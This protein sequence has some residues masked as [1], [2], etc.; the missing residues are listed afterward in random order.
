V[1]VTNL[2]ERL[3][4]IDTA[5]TIGNGVTITA[6]GDLT[7]TGD[8]LVSGDT[9]TMNTATMAVEDPLIS[10]ASGNAADSLDV[11][12]YAK[13]VSSGTKYAG[14]FRDASDSD[15]WKLFATTGNSHA[16]PT[17][18]VNTTSGFTLGTLVA[19]TFEGALTG[20]VTG[21][22][23]GNAD[24]VTDGVTVGTHA[25]NNNLAYF[26]SA[27]VISNTNNISITAVTGAADFYGSVE[28]G[29]VKIGTDTNKNT[30]ETSSAQ[31]LVLRTNGGTNS[32]TLTITDGAN[33]AITIAPN[34]SGA[35][36]ITKLTATNATLVTPALGTPSALVLTN[37]TAL[38]AAQVAQ[39]TMASGM[40]LVAPALGTPASGVLT[41]ATGLP[42]TSLT[43]T[44]TNAQLAG[45]IVYSKLSLTGAVL[46]AD[47]ASGIS[48]TKLT[49]GTIP[50]A[51]LGT[52]NVDTTHLADD[53]V[54]SDKIGAGEV[55]NTAL[56]ASGLSASKLTIGTLPDARY[57]S[58]ISALTEVGAKTAR[59]LTLTA[60]VSDN[61]QVWFKTSQADEEKYFHSGSG[62]NLVGEIISIGTEEVRV[63]S[64]ISVEVSEPISGYDYG[65]KVDRG[66]RGTT[67]AS[68]YSN[69][70]TL[71]ATSNR[72]IQTTATGSGSAISISM[73]E[74]S[75]ASSNVASVTGLVPKATT[76]DTAKYLRGDG[77]WQTVSAGGDSND[78]A[79][80]GSASAPSF[81]FTS[82]TNT[83]IFRSAADT[84]GFTTGGTKSLTIAGATT[85]FGTGSARAVLT[86]SGS[87]QLRLET[88]GTFPPQIT[89]DG[90]NS[91]GDISL[92][93]NG[94][95]S[96]TIGN[97][98]TSNNAGTTI[99]GATTTFGT[100][101]GT[102]QLKSNGNQ[103]LY[104][105]TGHSSTGSIN[106][107]AGADERIIL[108]PHGTGYV[109]IGG[110]TGI[111]VVPD[112]TASLP[113]Y[114]WNNDNNTGM[115]RGGTDILGFSTAGT[116]RMTIAADGVVTIA[117][118][119]SV[120]GT[121]ALPNDTV[122]QAMM[123]NGAIS[124]TQLENY[125]VSG[126]KI[127]NNNITN[128]HMTDDA[129]GLAEL[130]ATGT[131]SSSTY[132]RGDNTWATVSGG[133]TELD[134]LSDVNIAANFSQYYGNTVT[135]DN[136]TYNTSVGS[137][138]LDS[139]TTGSGN[140][141]FGAKAGTGITDSTANILIGSEAGT[142]IVTG[143]SHNI[144]IGASCMGVG[145]FNGGNYNIGL[146]SFTMR[147]ISTGD[148]N[149]GIGG[150]TAKEITTGLDNIGVGYGAIKEVTTGHRNIGIGT[151]SLDAVTTQ[152]NLI[153]I[154]YEAG[155]AVTSASNLTAIGHQSA[156]AITTQIECT[157]LGYQSGYGATGTHNTGVGMGA[158]KSITGNFNVAVGRNVAFF[159]GDMDFTTAIG[160]EAGFWWGNTPTVHDYT[161]AV[162]YQ[163]GYKGGTNS[164]YVGATT[165]YNQTGANAVAVGYQALRST[166]GAGSGSANT[167]IGTKSMYGGVGAISGGNNTFTGYKSGYLVSSGAGNSGFGYEALDNL[168]DGSNNIA[169]GYQAG[170]NISSGSN[171]VIIGKAD[172]ASATGS[173]QLSISSGDGS[174]VWIT[175]DSA[176]KINIGALTSPVTTGMLT[177]SRDD[178]NVTGPTL[179]LIDGDDDAN[180]G[181]T[182]KLYRDSASPADN[183]VLGN[184]GFNGEDSAGGE[185]T[186]AAIKAIAKDVTSGTNDGILE[187]K[188]MVAGTQEIVLELEDGAVTVN[189]AYTLPTTV[190]GAN[191]RVLTAQTDG[192]TAWAEAGGPNTD[193]FAFKFT[194]TNRVP[195]M[196]GVCGSITN[197]GMNSYWADGNLVSFLENKTL[198][199]AWIYINSLSEIEAVTVG[200][201]AALYELPSTHLIS[202]S[203]SATLIATASWAASKFVSATGSTGYNSVDWTVASGQSLQLDSSK[204]YAMMVSN[205]ANDQQTNTPYNIL[206]WS[207]GSLP[208]IV[209]SG[210]SVAVANGFQGWIN[211]TTSPA[212][213]LS[214][215]GGG[216]SARSAVWSTFT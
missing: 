181:P 177:V 16:V 173:D 149:I 193:S 71:S 213:T 63:I 144:G 14:L 106:M 147:S 121:L 150:W 69:S 215:S 32:G 89:I 86:S 101:S 113:S 202:S 45:S 57:N 81:A 130:S 155:T 131:A 22:L 136:A 52:G 208:C 91:N 2:E 146:G 125:A 3:P 200:V 185:R 94:T 84:I 73:P 77:T 196:N 176:G 28:A 190:T 157:Y 114:T 152:S 90:D 198:D 206:A 42:T 51:R 133:A 122:T 194:N 153:A 39:G 82:D 30:I 7:V 5:T 161:V 11:G 135:H 143:A 203:L 189:E 41:N 156:N 56:A 123:A 19:S 99:N 179:L 184:I 204:Y 48:A 37:A 108:T 172:V 191:D 92:Y 43:G 175:G 138:A 211:G 78:G 13:Y 112:G 34:G 197:K 169:I 148:N 103:N 55:D 75:G 59:S 129:I 110:G 124:E 20:D 145:N 38:P 180:A 76:S 199:K 187:F 10:M 117:N 140:T 33:G 127:Q 160:A 164:T 212:T 36:A 67:A 47:L 83:G 205:W 46:N 111:R 186:Y 1:N 118:G 188:T 209:G 165:A 49:T 134:G 24:T 12:F 4:Q 6:G 21:D 27:G 35:T 15:K 210:G 141:C 80:N 17:T 126:N 74:F 104:L 174:P 154:G 132:L 171:N 102:A 9:V 96:V 61:T 53:A 50:I 107:V 25:G 192:S 88:G 159:G 26:S 109:S 87:Q 195:M 214:L 23:T 128:A 170:D 207:S 54:D 151:S 168:R 85:T 31:D 100:G 93:P 163:A 158:G 201:T 72:T 64:A 166:A 97:W 167:A 137:T 70:T 183:D 62:I 116:S 68:S 44:I 139:I 29:N 58:G 40:V 119:L 120:S 79:D 216:S 95:G 182:L 162:G 66:V 105:T 178:A 8:L 98:F 18:T 65:L 115:Y 60:A 142:T